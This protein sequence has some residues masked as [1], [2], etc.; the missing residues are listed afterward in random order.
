[1]MMMMVVVAA[2]VEH[3]NAYLTFLVFIQES[4]QDKVLPCLNT[5][6]K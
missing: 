3:N 5:N 6:K 4:F 1:M 2:V